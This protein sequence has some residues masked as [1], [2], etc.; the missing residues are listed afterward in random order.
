MHIKILNWKR[1]N[2]RDDVKNPSWFRL[3]NNFLTDHEFFEL[4]SDQKMVWLALLAE[5]STKQSDII[6]ISPPLIAALTRCTVEVVKETFAYLVAKS[7][8][9]VIAEADVTEALRARDEHV[10]KRTSTGQDRTDRTEQTGQ[11]ST[12]GH[13]SNAPPEPEPPQDALVVLSLDQPKPKKARAAPGEKTA[14]SQVWSA[15]VAAYERRYG[16]APPSNAKGYALSSQLVARLGADDA[17]RVV[18]FYLTHN[19]AYYVRGVHP[20]GACLKDAEGLHT[21]MLAGHRMTVSEAHRADQGQGIMQAC[22][23]IA[24]KLTAEQEA[25]AGA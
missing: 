22:S 7:T 5:A 2:P 14:S 17:I 20:L 15:Y 4:T 25:R 24:A 9:E 23:D 12:E 21:Q 13:S 11:E 19:G 1:F 18:A 3:N 6:Y 16:H 8:I 10:R